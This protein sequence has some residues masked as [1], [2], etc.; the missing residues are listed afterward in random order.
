M[1]KEY[2][3]SFDD[4]IQSITKEEIVGT[5]VD[6]PGVDKT[7]IIDSK[8]AKTNIKNSHVSQQENDG[9]QETSMSAGRDIANPNN[10][11]STQDS[12]KVEKP[13]GISQAEEK[14]I[15]HSNFLLEVVVV[16]LKFFQFLIKGFFAL[17]KR[18]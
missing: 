16:P 15:V 18:R 11:R 13:P 8:V 2:G 6:F 7:R 12:S 9:A 1:I 17:I 3:K 5:I 10:P 4:I 14:E